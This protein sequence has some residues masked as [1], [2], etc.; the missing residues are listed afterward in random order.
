MLL[1]LLAAL[2]LP[3][4]LLALLARRSLAKCEFV[5]LFLAHM[6]NEKC[7]VVWVV[8]DGGKKTCEEVK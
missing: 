7:E 4:L 1:L 8:G 2:F 3:R 6:R 5:L